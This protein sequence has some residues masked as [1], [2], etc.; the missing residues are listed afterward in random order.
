MF[1]CSLACG[2]N[3]AKLVIKVDM[4]PYQGFLVFEVF[5]SAIVLLSL[6]L[7]RLLLFQSYQ[8]MRGSVHMRN[9]SDTYWSSD[10]SSEGI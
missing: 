3:V 9:I 10:T 2:V 1:N 5:L 8:C 7:W 6:H 4:H